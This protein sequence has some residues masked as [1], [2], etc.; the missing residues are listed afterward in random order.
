MVFFKIRNM[1]YIRIVCFALLS[2]HKIFH[3]YLA[4]EDYYLYQFFRLTTIMC[5]CWELFGGSTC[6]YHLPCEMICD[7][8]LSPRTV[9]D[10]NFNSST[11]TFVCVV[12]HWPS[13]VSPVHLCT[14]CQIWY[15]KFVNKTG[16]STRLY[17][18]CIVNI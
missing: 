13:K 17:S 10:W 11:L 2:F 14:K 8:T 1:V 15:V 4:S 9:F 16:W 12:G 18:P 5:L 6:F 7:I 3:F